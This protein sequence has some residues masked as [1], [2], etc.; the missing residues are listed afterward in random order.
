MEHPY[1]DSSSTWFLVELEF[2]NVDFWGEGK[3]GVPGEKPLGAR[4]RTNNKLNPHV[5]DAGIWTW[6]TLVAGECSHHCATLALRSLALD[7]Y[8][9]SF[10][11]LYCT[12]KKEF[13]KV[14]N[15]QPLCLHTLSV[16]EINSFLSH[17][18]HF[19][20]LLF[21]KP[22]SNFQD[23]VIILRENFL[24]FGVSTYFKATR[25]SIL[26]NSC[27]LSSKKSLTAFVK[28]SASWGG[29]SSYNP[30]RLSNATVPIPRKRKITMMMMMV[31]VIV[32]VVAPTT[33]TTMTMIAM[34]A[35][36]LMTMTTTMWWWWYR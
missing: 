36:M 17:V 23:S 16:G 21:N 15:N 6:A 2:G 3:T 25:L 7:F 31:E 10:V 29:V 24:Y 9:A 27:W 34:T 19:H 13:C 1:S 30:N 12:K 22:L 20:H 33:T 28:S 4:E 14:H 32:M 5:V 35:T 18:F 11:F 26:Y 8:M